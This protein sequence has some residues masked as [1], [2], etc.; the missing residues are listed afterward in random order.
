MKKILVIIYCLLT[1]TLFSE[2]YALEALGDFTRK[3]IN[4]EN[5]KCK[6]IV[7]NIVRIIDAW[8]PELVNFGMKFEFFLRN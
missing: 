1:S 6:I 3:E 8:A 5:K 4:L 7:L 2:E